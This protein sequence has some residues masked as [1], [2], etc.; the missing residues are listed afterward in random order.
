M[1]VH[2]YPHLDDALRALNVS[3]QEN[4]WIVSRLHTARTDAERSDVLATLERRLTKLYGYPGYEKATSN[5][6][7]A[8]SWNYFQ[9]HLWTLDVAVHLAERQLLRELEVPVANGSVVDTRGEIDVGGNQVTFFVEAK[10]W[11]FD[12]A[13]RDYSDPTVLTS[14]PRINKMVA[15]LSKQLPLD[16]FG[17]WAWDK[18]RDGLAGGMNLETGEQSLGVDERRIVDRVCNEVPQIACALINGVDP[19]SLMKGQSTHILRAVPSAKSKWT[20]KRISGLVEKLN[21]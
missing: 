11:R 3:T 18:L 10:S 8:T 14:D 17:V 6:L 5:L 2:G 12:P 16:A 7:N 20:A 1:N 4:S 9:E 13:L 15:R 21:T 19:M